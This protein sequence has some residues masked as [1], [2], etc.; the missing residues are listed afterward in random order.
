MKKFINES[1][2]CV[3]DMVDGMIYSRDDITRI[4]NTNIILHTD[5]EQIKH[6]QVTLLSGGGSGH[7]PAHAGYIGKGMLTGAILGNVFASPS[8]QS[9]LSAIRVCCGPHGL[10]LIVKN[11]T[12][13]RLNFGIAAERAKSEG[14][15][16]EMVIVDDDCALEIGKGITGGRG[17]AGTVFIHKIAGAAASSGLTLLEV[18]DIVSRSC[19]LVRS[20]G[21]A[22]SICTLPGCSS[23]PRLADNNSMEFGIGIHGEPGHQI[24][25][26]PTIHVASA[27]VNASLN[28]IL[29]STLS[30]STQSFN[31][32]DNA[33][34]GLSSLPFSIENRPHL[35]LSPGSKVA[36]LLNNLGG[37]SELEMAIMSKEIIRNLLA[38][39]ITPIRF[40]C[41]TFMSSLDMAGV[42]I[43]LLHLDDD[44]SDL[45]RYIDSITSAPGDK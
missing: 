41:G 14:L 23:S 27:V 17:V 18:R 19:T 34:S 37:V 7:E 24:Q 25:M 35:N 11:Y 43:S 10:L 4:E 21:C 22:L 20:V 2:S 45:L 6:S 33:L 28:V 15:N 26:D 38:R 16:V 32:S 31:A 13:D 9:V 30:S 42:S 29:G 12:G 8:V 40:Y 1:S 36:V 44:D 39:S 5:V 3:K